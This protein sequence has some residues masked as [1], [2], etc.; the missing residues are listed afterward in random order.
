MEQPSTQEV[1]TPNCFMLFLK[2]FDYFGVNFSFKIKDREKYQSSFGGL[3]FILF[4]ALVIV[5]I[6]ITFQIF[7]RREVYT[8]NNSI[9]V[10]KPAPQIGFQNNSFSLAISLV[11]DDDT[12]PDPSILNYF[13]L[14]ITN[15]ILQNSFKTKTLIPKKN[16]ELTDFF[17]QLNN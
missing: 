17:N 15:T 10:L 3:V 1:K 11:N 6:V 2:T 14:S 5:Y 12:F 13:N 4:L 8:I 16:C 7:L 9:T